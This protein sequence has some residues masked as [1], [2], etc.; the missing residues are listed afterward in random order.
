[1]NGFCENTKNEISALSFSTKC[2]KRAF[3][4]ALI[5]S[6]GS[7]S[8]NSDGMK[9]TL[10]LGRD[11]LVEK[12]FAF[13]KSLFGDKIEVVEDI[14]S[15]VIFS[16]NYLV[17]A[18][19]ELGIFALNE[20][21]ETVLY[22][23]IARGL[24]GSRCCA[25]NYIRGLF[26]GCGSVSLKQRYHLEF[27]LNSPALATDLVSLF[28][29][30][31]FSA[32]S[33]ERKDKVVVYFKESETISDCLA[34][35]GASKAVIALN[36]EYTMREF[37]RNT[38]RQTN[39]EIAN[40]SKT[41]NASVRQIESIRLI[42]SKLGLASLDDKLALVARARLDY[43]DESFAFLAQTLNISKS[44]L[45][46]RLNKLCEIAGAIRSDN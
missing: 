2:C 41:V 22:A 43:P 20:R 10:P 13:S 28:A 40:I 39:C 30:L 8:F 42:E 5:H 18:L 35:M 45:K 16:G 32:K 7:L 17:Q 26:L 37:R 12:I 46:N 19:L 34:L 25:V 3:L 11:N 4:S 31:G 15:T 24:I 6:C 33:T 1:M 21:G 36:E 9:I 27:A 14:N 23:G 44:T 38:N 29:K